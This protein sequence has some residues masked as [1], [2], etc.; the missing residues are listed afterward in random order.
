MKKLGV[1]DRYLLKDLALTTLFC[2]LILCVLVSIVFAMK[3]VSSGYSL[4]IVI[5]WLGDSLLYSMYFTTPMSVMAGC[6]LSYGKFVADREFTAAVASGI[7]PSRLFLP[8]TILIIPILMMM[9]FTQSTLLPELQHR[10]QDISRFFVKQL[11]NIGDGRKG[12]IPLDGEGGVIYWE[13]IRNGTDLKVV[14]IEKQ[15]SVKGGAA[16]PSKSSKD[17]TPPTK[18]NAK[19]A[20]LS[21]D[22]SAGLIRLTLRDVSVVF[23]V[24]SSATGQRDFLDW[25]HESI[26]FDQFNVDFPISSRNRRLNDLPT[27]ELV[28]RLVEIEGEV[29]EIDRSLATLA[30]IEEKRKE[31]SRKS[32][33]I[34]AIRRGETEIWRRR[35]MAL[36]VLTF[37]M[38]GAPLALLL[39][40][41]QK[42]VP[43]FFSLL[44]ILGVFYPLTYG[45]VQLSRATGA[46]AW[47]TV[48]SGNYILLAMAIGMILR[49]RAR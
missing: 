11:E 42:L 49:L 33:L 48:L 35:A 32:G 18:I 10:K 43:F 31:E 29:G 47:I 20:K 14:Y 5:P 2:Q 25:D 21:V 40:T 39:R 34:R 22:D 9:M 19:R 24:N 7:S 41:P 8:M 45:G 28:D 36:A 27:A 1:L 30:S 17:D 37:A 12:Q 15:L 4:G 23:P 3:A 16:V 38:I 26:E 46:P 6:S 13:E 44:A